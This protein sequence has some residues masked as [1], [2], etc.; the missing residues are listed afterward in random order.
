[1]N[2]G[3]AYSFISFVDWRM[4]TVITSARSRSPSSRPSC[5]SMMRRSFSE[6]PLTFGSSECRN[7]SR[8][9]TRSSKSETSSSSFHLK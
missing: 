8:R 6:A 4:M 5:S 9:S 3:A 1:M 7:A 2:F